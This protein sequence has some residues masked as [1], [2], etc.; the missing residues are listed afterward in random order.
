MHDDITFYD[1]IEKV[2][3]YND[4]EDELRIIEK[5]YNYA[6]EKHFTQKRISRD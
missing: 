2:R 3:K 4:D 5:A 1:L 6:K